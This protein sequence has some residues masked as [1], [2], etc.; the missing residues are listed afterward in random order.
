MNPLEAEISNLDRNIQY[1]DSKPSSVKESLDC[2]I[3]SNFIRYGRWSK[4]EHFRFMKGIYC[5]GKNWNEIQRY[6]RTRSAPQCRAH[7][8]K[9][10]S[11]ILQMYREEM[12]IAN[13][14]RQKNKSLSKIRRHHEETKSFSEE[15]SCRMNLSDVN[16]RILVSFGLLPA[17]DIE[18]CFLVNEEKLE[19]L[20]KLGKSDS[21]RDF[22][23]K[24]RI[25]YRIPKFE[26]YRDLSKVNKVSYEENSYN[27]TV[28]DELKKVYELIMTNNQYQVSSQPD[29]IHAPYTSTFDAYDDNLF[30]NYNQSCQNND[31][32]PYL[33]VDFMNEVNHIPNILE[34]YDLEISNL[35]GIIGNYVSLKND[36]NCLALYKEMQ[37]LSSLIYL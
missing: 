11:K 34:E 2:K 33:I 32:I 21:N 5:Y 13:T 24:S 29:Y 27:Q 22:Q 28:I 9:Y 17:E 6:V 1:I 10:L 31:L 12:G 37:N 8:Q 36:N 25:K 19:L 23:V 16:K 15:S 20:S 7:A 3:A 26:V 18:S 35:V 4:A 30:D 14:R